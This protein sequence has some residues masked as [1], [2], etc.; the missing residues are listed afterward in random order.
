MKKHKALR[1]VLIVVGVLVVLAVVGFGARAMMFRHR[2]MPGMAGHMDHGMHGDMSCDG[3]DMSDDMPC[4]S[5]D[6]CGM[7]SHRGHMRGGYRSP[8]GGLLILGLLALGAMHLFHMH[9]F[10]W[11]MMHGHMH[12]GHMPSGCC[13][14]AGHHHHTGTACCEASEVPKAEPTE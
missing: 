4:N 12:P 10:R 14:D 13:C 7:I 8:L 5:G 3:E 11:M 2:Y 1:V 9:R 6:S